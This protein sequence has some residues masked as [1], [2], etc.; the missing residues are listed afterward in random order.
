MPCPHGGAVIM[1]IICAKDHGRPKCLSVVPFEILLP[2]GPL[3]WL[4]F[5]HFPSEGD[6]SRLERTVWC[7]KIGVIVQ[8]D[9]STG[10]TYMKNHHCIDYR[11]AWSYLKHDTFVSNQN[12][13][14]SLQLIL[15]MTKKNCFFS[16]LVIYIYI[17][18]YVY[19]EFLN[20]EEHITFK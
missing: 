11:A 3:K 2:K 5:S 1:Q 12:R 4:V 20:P 15:E 14:N 9:R 13:T 6:I 18:S 16:S 17:N 19:C 10:S 7:K 8:A